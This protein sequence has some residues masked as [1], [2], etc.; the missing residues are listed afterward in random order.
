MSRALSPALR[1]LTVAGLV[2]DAVIHFKL[3]SS[4]PPSPPGQ[5]GQ[6]LLFNAEGVASVV[7]A[8]LVLAFGMRWTYVVA[9]TVAGS[10]LAAVLLSRYVDIGVIGPL[11]DMYEPMWYFDKALTTAAEAIALITAT[12]AFFVR[13]RPHGTTQASSAHMAAAT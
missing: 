13:R 8:V 5:L 7:A 6:T 3:A 2:I 4:Q 9:A 10:A 1:L 11:P 12:A